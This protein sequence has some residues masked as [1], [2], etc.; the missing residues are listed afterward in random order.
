LRRPSTTDWEAE[1]FKPEKGLP[2]KLSL[3]RWKLGRK[4]KQEPTFRFFTLYD[5]IYRRDTLKAAWARV[6]AN[7]GA[8][9][10]D[11]VSFR[12]IEAREGGLEAFLDEIEQALKTK[13]YEPQPVRRVYIPKANGKLRPLGIPCVRDRLVQM[14]VLLILEPIF[15]EDFEECSHGFRPGRQ[16]QDALA[17]IRANLNAGRQEVYDADLS[18]YFDTI[19]HDRLMQM[20]ER[21]IADRSVLHLI[22]MWLKCAIVEEDEQGKRKTT[23]PDKGTPQGGVISPLLANVYLHSMDSAFHEDPNGPYQSANARLVRYADDFV[24]MARW[25][26][27]RIERWLEEKLEGEL[28]L[29]INREKTHTVRMHVE[30]ERLNFLGY[31]FRYDRDILGRDKRYLNVFPSEKSEKRVREK[32][33]EILGHTGRPIWEAI[34]EVQAL[35]RGWAQY[36]K[37]GYPRK[38]FR[39]VNYYVQEC[40]RGY[41]R[42]QS[43]RRSKPFRKGETL[44]AGLRRMGFAP[45]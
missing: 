32:I 41:I 45:L 15:E 21:R 13:T 16:A 7:K 40:F 20:I 29:T 2:E 36:F 10:V 5:R 22:R 43:Q 42:R 25:M 31:T 33:K 24:V 14:A 44:Y 26:G 18:S 17:Q 38:V 35:L 27:P 3:L 8:P 39:A 9:G 6:R 11:G 30:G 12:D 34:D 37:Y 19:P 23:K 4:A 1:G 28:G